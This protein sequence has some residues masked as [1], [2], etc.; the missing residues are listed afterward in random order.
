MNNFLR[1]VPLFAGLSEEDLNRLCEMVSEMRLPGGAELFAEGSPGD[2]A[3]VIREGQVEIVKSSAGREVLLA[4]RQPGDVIGEIALLD[5]AP[6]MASARARSDC[7]LIVI[8]QE[9]LDHLV[10][11]SPTAARSLLQ[12]VTTRFRSTNIMLRQSEKMAQLGA[13]TAGMAHELNNPAAAVQ[14]GAD[15]LRNAITQMQ[16]VQSSLAD[17][18]LPSEQRETLNKLEAL[19]LQ[20]AARQLDLDVLERS[21]RETELESWLEEQGVPR[22]WE[23]APNLVNQGLDPAALDELAQ[24][25]SHQQLSTVLAW[26]NA[27]YIANSLVAEVSQG[28]GRISEIVK[29]LKMYVYL[30]QGPVQ[31][32]DIHEGLDSTLVLLHAKLKA[33]GSNGGI[34][35]QREYAA[36]LP[37][38]QAYGSE[39]NQ[40]W[41]H[42]ID[43][44]ADA[45]Q[46]SGQII[47]RTRL[48]A[49]WV[50]VEVEDNGPGI[51]L[52]VQSQVFDPFFTTKP[53]GKGAGLGLNISY[54]I[55]MK[56]A[57]TIRLFSHPGKTVFQV[58][59]PLDF[60]AA[61]PGSTPTP[62]AGIRRLDDADLRA[63]L[64]NTRSIAVVGISD[65]P[66]RASHSVP[67]YLQSHGYRLVPV[68]PSLDTIL[69]EK[70]YPSLS[71]APERVDVVLIFRQSEAVP[72][73]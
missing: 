55:V 9:Q 46:G 3:Y 57:G 44:A 6:R 40:V 47:L 64:E 39:L 18:N 21:D 11:L 38:I 49:P 69:G 13:L 63:I 50:V 65:K 25:F 71:A 66:D 14:R 2:Q 56:H 28:A 24:G 32:V 19:A 27:V 62:V 41:T 68:N 59:L 12:S 20:K 15:Q 70:C 58:R 4:V 53:P 36:N 42:L 67:A 23:L 17:L 51:P 45:L 1:H 48:E 30:D 10:S 54:N 52:V 29:A 33:N 22:G 73:I 8:S 34:A 26:L 60:N 7:R 37:H 5:A 31:P 43:N 35:V 61:Q 16:A 72:G